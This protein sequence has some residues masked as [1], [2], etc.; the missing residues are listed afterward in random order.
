MMIVSIS[1]W[2]QNIL[3]CIPVVKEVGNQINHVVVSA[4]NGSAIFVW[5]DNRAGNYNIYAQRIDNS[6]HMQWLDHEKG[7]IVVSGP[8]NKINLSAVSDNDG[9]AIISWQ[10]DRMGNQDI[11]AQWINDDGDIQ[12]GWPVTGRLICDDTSDQSPPQMVRDEDGGAYVAWSDNRGGDYD[13]YIRR[14][15]LDGSLD[16]ST[17]GKRVQLLAESL[18]QVNPAIASDGDHGAIIAYEQYSG[19][20]SYD[21]FAQRIDTSLNNM[22]DDGG[23]PACIAANDQR[24]PSLINDALG[25]AII[26]WEDNVN[27]TWDIYAQR[28]ANN[29]IQWTANGVAIM[30]IA[31]DQINPVLVPAGENSAIIVWEHYLSATDSNIYAQ[32][33]SG[34]TTGTLQWLATGVPVST[35]HDSYQKN[36]QAVTDGFGGVIVVYET[37]ENYADNGYD[38]YANRLNQDGAYTNAGQ[39]GGYVVCTWDT[40][41]TLPMLAYS[42]TAENNAIYAWLDKRNEPAAG[43]HDIYTLGVVDAVEYT[44]TVTSHDVI[45]VGGSDLGAEILFNGVSFSNPIYT[46]YV[47]GAPGNEPLLAGTY[48]VV[49]PEYSNWEPESVVITDVE[50]NYATDFLGIRYILNVTSTPEA[51]GIYQDA[52][53]TGMLTNASFYNGDLSALLGTYTMETA[54]FGFH[55]APT[56]I[57]VVAGNFTAANNYTYTIHFELIDETLPVE[58]S[59]F[60]ASLTFQNFVNL[61]WISQ[62]ETGLLGYRVYRNEDS[63]LSSAIVITPSLIP[64]TNTSSTHVYN[65]LDP[66][67]SNGHVYYY[68][69]ESVDMNSTTFHGPVSARVE[70]EVPPVLPESTM[71]SNA[72]PNPFKISS[73]TTINVS[74]KA[75][76][77]GKVNIYNV[78]GQ[79]IRS[80][81]VT[82]GLNPLTWDGRD[83]K[84]NTCSSGIY[85]YKLQTPSMNQTKK[86]VIIK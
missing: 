42:T 15:F 33:I 56:S 5:Q 64:A 17:N 74:V 36:P 60:T 55:W 68:W 71:M 52:V 79:T 51:Y 83:S 7:K 40:D 45:E 70:N 25:S 48:T 8:S 63:N 66:E 67:V 54:P 35:T 85:F 58:L 13:I 77:V 3:D 18:N 12:K 38:I 32:K 81:T 80:F 49:H 41:Q 73:S 82:E 9:G 50:Q 21:I 4:N 11:Y 1:I 26:V 75:G 72:Y 59:S 2:S 16:S 78:M 6:G 19:P 46:G 62:T 34:S 24:N 61:T 28:V 20:G 69:L 39:L 76:E 10:D 23:V 27:F 53:A 57:D 30:A 43:I 86:L 84:G 47:F 65:H 29:T 22:W 44:Y 37:A 31:L 14:I